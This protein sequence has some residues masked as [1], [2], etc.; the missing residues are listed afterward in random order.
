MRFKKLSR[1][2]L[3]SAGLEDGIKYIFTMNPYM[4]ELLSTSEFIQTDI[5]YNVS[6]ECTYLSNAVAFD[7]HLMEWEVVAKVHLS[8]QNSDVY[9]LAFT[10][11][12]KNAK[13]IIPISSQLKPFWEYSDRLVRY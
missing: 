11:M 5:A 1:P 3:V 10:K 4:S 2:Y 6:T 9:A 12:F 8:H 7:Y 13:R